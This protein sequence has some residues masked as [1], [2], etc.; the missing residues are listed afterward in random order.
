M[1]TLLKESHPQANRS[2]Q[3]FTLIE[4]LVVISIILILSSLVFLMVR[5]GI[6]SAKT[7]ASLSNLRQL[8]AGIMSA[9]ADNSMN[10]P[11]N[12]FASTPGVTYP[13]DRIWYTCIAKYVYPSIYDSAPT[14]NTSPMNRPDVGYKGTI[15]ISPNAENLRNVSIYPSSYGYNF[16]FDNTNPPY[17]YLTRY[18]ATRTCMFADNNGRTHAL[19]GGPND[20]SGAINPRNGASGP[21]TRDGKAAAIFLDGHSETFS[22]ARARELNSDRDQEFWGLTSS[23]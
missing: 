15:L 17:S 20:A 5:R 6:D 10:L 1:K 23:P 8:H 18:D 3:G 4:I 22:A 16:R 9:A 13:R 7:T 21:F 11:V 14:W 12:Y 19:N 2:S